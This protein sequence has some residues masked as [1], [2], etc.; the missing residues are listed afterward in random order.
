[1]RTL[2]LP[3]VLAGVVGLILVA[4]APPERAEVDPEARKLL[5]D[6]I[7]TYKGLDAYQDH[8]QFRI[9]VQ[10]DGQDQDRAWPLALTFQRPGKVA[11]DAGDARLVDDGKTVT[12]VMPPTKNYLVLPAPEAVTMTT[13][14]EGPLGA[15]LLGGPGGSSVRMLLSL[16]V[17]DD[18]ARVILEGEAGL[19]FGE[20]VVLDGKTYRALI[21]DRSERVDERLL[22]D[23]ETKLVHAIELVVTPEDLGARAPTGTKLADARI[24][25]RS[26]AISTEAPKP[27][28]FAFQAPEGFA[29]VG[30]LEN[31]DAARVAA[32]PEQHELVGK[33]APE[34]TLSVLDGE[35]KTR[36]IHKADLAGK[37]V[38]LDFWA[39]WCPPCLAELP[40]VARMI[41]WYNGEGKPVVIIAVSQDRNPEDGSPVRTLV[42]D[43][44]KNKKLGLMQGEVGKVAL[45]PSQAVGDAFQVQALPTVVILDPKGTVQA[46]HVGYREGVRETLSGEIN[47][48]L[49]GESLVK[50]K[51]GDEK[52]EKE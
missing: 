7:A 48:L 14:T 49:E 17:A 46:V 19:T 21:V 50:P 52:A 24:G 31:P 10:I 3:H 38:M 13:I 11:L 20:E 39:T 43:L 35:G 25:W 29:Q 1:M 23:P 37:V 41:E 45:D 30:A 2:R 34:F 15:M 36:S 40:E 51:E 32:N 33:P 27:E 9:A 28:T 6:V 16:L 22:I 12:I 44:L 5:D 26:G 42:E 4:A 18:P 8:G 47:T